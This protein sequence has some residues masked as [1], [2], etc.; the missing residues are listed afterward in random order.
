MFPFS[1]FQSFARGRKS[2]KI[3]I[4]I[5]IHHRHLLGPPLVP[6]CMYKQVYPRCFH[7]TLCFSTGDHHHYHDVI[8]D[9]VDDDDVDDDVDTNNVVNYDVMNIVEHAGPHSW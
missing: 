2:I 6:L 9:D 7:P 8:D 5:T 4:D 3:S 1:D